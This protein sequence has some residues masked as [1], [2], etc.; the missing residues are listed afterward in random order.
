MDDSQCRVC[1]GETGYQ[2]SVFLI[3]GVS[4]AEQ[5]FA[6]TSVQ[7]SNTPVFFILFTF[8][9]IEFIFVDS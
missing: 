2:M 3:D 9:K 5:L 6:V 7:V 8:C 4:I 1:L